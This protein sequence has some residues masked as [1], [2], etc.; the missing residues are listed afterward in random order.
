MIRFSYQFNKSNFSVTKLT[1]NYCYRILYHVKS[2]LPNI[3]YQISYHLTHYFINISS[4]TGY[5]YRFPVFFFYRVKY[6]EEVTVRNNCI[7]TFCT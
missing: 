5:Y 3:A 2:V 7:T 1:L 6:V 4:L